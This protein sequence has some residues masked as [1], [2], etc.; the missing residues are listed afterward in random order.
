MLLRVFLIDSVNNAGFQKYKHDRVIV[1]H[2]VYCNKRISPIF[3][4]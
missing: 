3:P 1:H 4:R 2:I